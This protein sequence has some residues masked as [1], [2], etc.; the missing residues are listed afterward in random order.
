MK[1]KNAQHTKGPWKVEPYKFSKRGSWVSHPASVQAAD[2]HWIAN[3]ISVHDFQG[4]A[5]ANA[6][7]IAA[8]PDL[9]AALQAV[10][11]ECAFVHKHWGEDDNTKAANAA[12]T[13][14]RAAIARATGEV[15]P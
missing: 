14:A 11:K 12:E 10:L 15:Q 5:M 7:L 3:N 8:S 4:S 1:T 9:L 6:R 13:A 2:G